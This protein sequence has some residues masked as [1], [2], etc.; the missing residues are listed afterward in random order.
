M[1]LSD[2]WLARPDA[3]QSPRRHDHRSPFQRDRARILHSAAFRRLQAKTQVLGVGQADF[4]RTR[5]THSLEAAQIGT[6][7]LAQLRHKYPKLQWL[8]P[9]E[10]LVDALCLA[11]DI[12]HPPFGHGGEVALNYMMREAGGFEGNGQT[13]RIL[14]RLEPYTQQNGMNLCRRTLLG[15]LKY[16]VLASRCQGPLPEAVTNHRQLRAADWQPPKAIY[17]DDKAILDWILAPLSGADQTRFSQ[18]RTTRQRH[19]KAKYKSLDC[20]IMELGDDIAYSVHD[21]EDAIVMGLVSAQAWQQD[22]QEPIETLAVPWLSDNMARLSEQMFSGEHFLRK[23]AIG[24]MVNAFITSIELMQ[25]GE[26]DSPLL[27]WNAALPGPYQ[28]ALNVLKGFVYR[29]VVKQPEL[30][31]LEYKGQQMVMGL[32]EAMASDPQRLLPQSTRVRWQEARE[33]GENALRVIADYI[34]GMT[35]DYAGRLYATLFLPKAGTVFERQ[36]Q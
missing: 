12:G 20:S 9:D 18:L 3:D 27:D 36:V 8:L 26:F 32:F 21:L 7:I 24:A 4:Y 1:T 23:D 25:L 28:Q 10:A 19:A 16:P 11:H 29:H 2:H 35:D 30:Q 14:A 15:V 5:L 13:L 6:G 34:A 17:D 31:L 33:K 22:V